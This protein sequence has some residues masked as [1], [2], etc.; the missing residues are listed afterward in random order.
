MTIHRMGILGTASVASDFMREA[1][2]HKKVKVVAVSSRTKEKARRFSQQWSLPTVMNDYESLINSSEIDIVYIPLPNSLHLEWT[3]RALFAGKHV[4]CEKPLAVRRQTATK[5]FEIAKSNN[6][7]LLEGFPFRFQSYFNKLLKEIDRGCIGDVV[8]I[9]TGFGYT[10]QQVDNIRFDKSL[11]GGALLDAGCYAVCF[12]RAVMKSAPRRVVATAMS[13][14]KGVDIRTH[15]T[16]E[17]SNQSVC[18]LNCSLDSDFHRTAEII[19]T[20]GMIEVSYPNSPTKRN[21]ARV[22]ITTDRTDSQLDNIQVI[23]RSPGF[24]HELTALANFIDHER[25]D[26]KIFQSE[27][28]DNAATLSAI[29]QSIRSGTWCNVSR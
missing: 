7:T 12:A 3:E 1:E 26:I 9:N 24:D 16:M 14:G 13:H 11:D 2:C 17:Y 27:S 25:N 23:T 21:P 19:G 22:R 29:R 28:E 10:V 8:T 20:H 18:Q 4:L 5:L 6:L 15:A